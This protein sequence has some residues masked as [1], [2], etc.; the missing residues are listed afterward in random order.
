MHQTAL[1]GT[2]IFLPEAPARMGCCLLLRYVDFKANSL[3][4]LVQHRLQPKVS[5]TSLCVRRVS[6]ARRNVAPNCPSSAAKRHTE[7]LSNLLIDGTFD[8][9]PMELPNAS[10]LTRQWA[11]RMLLGT[12]VA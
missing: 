6:Q 1:A 4:A 8:G 7:G 2:I 11:Q 5:A 10:V 9:L 12:P 3:L